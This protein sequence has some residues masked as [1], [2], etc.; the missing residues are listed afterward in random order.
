LQ[1]TFFPSKGSDRVVQW[2]T[3][4]GTKLLETLACAKSL[5]N[6][7]PHPGWAAD[8]QETLSETLVADRSS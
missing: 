6:V 3:S 2:N 5:P 8:R 7:S 1:I 4:L